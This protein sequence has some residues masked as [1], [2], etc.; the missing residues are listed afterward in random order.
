[1]I[2]ILPVII[3][4]IVIGS[5]FLNI[6]IE[7]II[8]TTQAQKLARDKF[9]KKIAKAKAILAKHPGMKQITEVKQAFKKSNDK[10]ACKKSCKKNCCKKSIMQK[11]KEIN[12]LKEPQEAL[13]VISLLTLIYMTQ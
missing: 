13:I 8:M 3:K 6:Y 9:K 4:P 2:D 12:M 7:Y 1:M 5:I 10:K 11:S